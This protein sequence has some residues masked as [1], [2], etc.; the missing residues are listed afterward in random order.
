MQP[1]PGNKLLNE[2]V[3]ENGNSIRGIHGPTLGKICGCQDQPL[4][5]WH[6]YNLNI[7][8]A[9]YDMII[10][11]NNPTFAVFKNNDIFKLVTFRTLGRVA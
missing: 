1:G 3:P 5:K 4:L 2:H 9:I 11:D 6:A 8:L 10:C 7:L